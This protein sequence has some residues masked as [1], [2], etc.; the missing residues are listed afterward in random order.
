AANAIGRL[1][2]RGDTYT[3]E[4]PQIISALQAF[5][6]DEGREGYIIPQVRRGGEVKQFV[7]GGTAISLVGKKDGAITD[8]VVQDLTSGE[9]T[10]ITKT[11]G[12]DETTIFSP[13]ERLGMVMSTRGSKKTD[14]AIFGLLP[15]PHSYAAE[16]LIMFLYMYAV[17]GVRSFRPGNVGP[18]LIEIER[19]MNES[20]YQGVL[21]ND[22]EEKWVYVSPMSWH[23]SGK[24]AMWPETLRG[25]SQTEG[26]EQT[27]VRQVTLHDH[28]TGDPVPVQKTSDH[29][30][31]GIKGEEGRL[32]LW[33]PPDTYVE[34]KI[35]GRHSG[36]VD[37][38]SRDAVQTQYVNYSDD[39][40]TFYDGVE[41]MVRSLEGESVYEADLEMTG[42][43][44]GAMQLRATFSEIS[45]TLP[46]KLMFDAAPDGKHKKIGRAHV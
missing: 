16:G 1:V 3:I 9:L 21:L 5:E 26:G 31:Y 44:Q 12:Y 28:R 8:S 30:P 27:R 39:G 7:R 45:F 32:S 22:P 40:R 6:K 36:Y 23:P 33:S 46:P 25:S 4:Q 24:K 2:R 14:P 18:V 19:S 34:G 37:Y 20:G 43:Q 13:D 38:T 29:I 35:A 10:Q 11:P 41:R 42:A 15:R 17:A